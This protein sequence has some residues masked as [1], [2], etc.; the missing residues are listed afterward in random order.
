MQCNT[1]ACDRCNAC[2]LWCSLGAEAMVLALR[3][4]CLIAALLQAREDGSFVGFSFGSDESPPSGAR[5]AGLRFQTTHAFCVFFRP[6]SEWSLPTYANKPPITREM[7]LCDLV[8]CVGKTGTDVLGVLVQ[9]WA[10]FGLYK[11]D[12]VAGVGDG[13]GEN[14]GVGGIHTL[15]EREMPDYVRR[16]CFGHL[17][18]RVADQGLDAMGVLHDNTKA[19]STYLHEGV[20]WSRLKALAVQPISNGG[21]GLLADGSA[22]YDAVFGASPPKTMDERPETTAELLGWLLKRQSILGRLAKTDVEQRSL[23]SK[24]AL[25]AR[26]SLSSRSDA[27]MRHVAYGLVK[28]ALFLFYYAKS[29]KHIALHDNFTDLINRAGEI[30]TSLR[31][32]QSIL[33]MFAVSESDLRAAGLEGTIAVMSWVEVAIWGVDGMSCEEASTWAQPCLEFHK[34]V[35]LRMRAHLSLTAKNIDGSTWLSARRRP[36][37]PTP[38]HSSILCTV[39]ASPA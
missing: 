17:P 12:C 5:H 13:G 39:A 2:V 36:P 27:I 21:L 37:H 35:S 4:L 38:A 34:A 9:Q 26:D 31:C 33:D 29:K 20:T 18:W 7:Y 23:Q 6:M 24:A 3:D 1:T 28:K 14:E 10:R 11:S 16:R 15:L 30:I 32:D 8:N 25:A 19:I 22:E